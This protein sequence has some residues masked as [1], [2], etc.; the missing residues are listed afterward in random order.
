M[1][2]S[3]YTFQTVPFQIFYILRT[4][5]YDFSLLLLL[6][7]FL[8]ATQKISPHLSQGS[9]HLSFQAELSFLV[10]AAE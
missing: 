4:L 8:F 10:W 2:K 7:K 1:E 5:P 6:F 9:N 3:E